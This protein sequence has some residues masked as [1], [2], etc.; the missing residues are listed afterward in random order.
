VTNRGKTIIIAAV[1]VG[2]FVLVF[3]AISG[4]LVAGHRAATR[5]GN[6]A[7]TIQNLKTIGAVEIQYFDTHERTFGTFEQLVSEH[8]LSSRFAEQP[9]VV[10]G[11]VFTLS[12]S[13]KSDGSSGYRVTD[14]P[15]DESGGTRH[16]YLDSD[17][18]RIHVNS[19]HQAGPGDPVI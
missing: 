4:V 13:R 15:Q 14:D 17:N 12:V 8:L 3:V 16:F 18:G 19:E 2:I 7:A 11:Y 6:E 9:T 5:A 10:D 1:I